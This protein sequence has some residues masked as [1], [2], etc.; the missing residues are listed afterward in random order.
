[1][2][3]LLCGEQ[4]VSCDEEENIMQHGIWAK[5]GIE[6][7]HFPFTGKPGIKVDS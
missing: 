5:S 2:K 3:I 4:S 7:P 1:V 6:R